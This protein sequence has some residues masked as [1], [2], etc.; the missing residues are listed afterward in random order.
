M[1][2]KIGVLFGGVSSEHEISLLS[3]AAVL[4][5]INPEQYE[6]HRVGITKT[7]DWY[8]YTGSNEDIA[9]GSWLSNAANLIPCTVNVNRSEAGLLLL[10]QSGVKSIPLDCVF[11]VLHGKNGEDGTIQGLLEIAGIPYVGCG[12]LA[13]A[14]CMDKTTTHALLDQNGVRTARYLSIMD[15]EYKEHGEEFLQYAKETLKYP[16]FVK[17]ANAGSSVGISKVS[18]DTAFH[19]AM[20]LAFEHDSKVLVEEMITGLEVECSVLGNRDPIAAVP[21]SIVSC[22][23]W[24][25]YEAKYLAGQTKTIIPAAI[26]TRLIDKVRAQAIRAYIALGCTGMA[27]VDFFVLPDEQV[28]VNEVNTIPGFTSISM[29]AKMFAAAGISFGELVDRLLHLALAAKGKDSVEGD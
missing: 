12:T 10:E 2:K 5:N 13:S 22:N 15:Y 9:N 20:Q 7:G 3:A 26:S 25:D 18:D 23:E 14:V 8:Y 27:R 17:P 19:R 29:Y 6:V 1:K 4:E 16:V 21:G 24:Y 28:I 11:P